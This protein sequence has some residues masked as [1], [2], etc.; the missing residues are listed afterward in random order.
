MLHAH[1]SILIESYPFHS[2]FQPGYKKIGFEIRKE[3]KDYSMWIALSGHSSTQVSQSTQSFTLTTALSS[4]SSI[5]ADG[6]IST[7]VA[8]PVHFSLLTTAGIV[9]H[10]LVFTIFLF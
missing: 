2:F 1:I 7:Q 6:Q 4:L 5:A 8:H 10:P 9:I 3:K